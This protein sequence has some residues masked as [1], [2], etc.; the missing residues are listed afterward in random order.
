MFR[1]L[2]LGL[3]TLLAVIAL[4]GAV[5]ATISG[6]AITCPAGNPLVDFPVRIYVNHSLWYTATTDY[7]GWYIVDTTG[8]DLQ[9]QYLVTV[10]LGAE[11]WPYKGDDCIRQR[12]KY[13]DGTPLIFE[14]LQLECGVGKA[15]PCPSQ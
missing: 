7:N 6:H 15:P 14:D 4:T 5:G 2:I 10:S 13:V 1:S 9:Y 12:S 8:W 11:V 3:M